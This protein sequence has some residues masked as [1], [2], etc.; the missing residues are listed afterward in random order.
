M[1]I[2]GTE[3]TFSKEFVLSQLQTVKDPIGFLSK[4]AEKGYR[5]PSHIVIIPDG[6]AR[7]AHTHNQKPITV[8]HQEGARTVITLVDDLKRLFPHMKTIT[9][10]A[11]SPDNIKNR[12]QQEING[13]MQIINNSLLEVRDK[14]IHDNGKIIHLGDKEGLPAFL[15]KSLSDTETLSRNNTGLTIALA[16]NFNGEQEKLRIV[17][18]SIKYSLRR[19]LNKI[20]KETLHQLSDPYT[21][22]P[23]ELIIRTGAERSEG[24]SLSG[25]GLDSAGTQLVFTPTLFPSLSARELAT[26]IAGYQQRRMGGR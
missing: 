13:L 19:G 20:N 10:W 9:I 17:N 24:Q 2:E 12:S 8:G 18:E 14:L 6:N 11:L 16:I 21:L 26:I 4:T 22:G 23:A 3:K 7:W 1:T 15:Q 5:I 25:L